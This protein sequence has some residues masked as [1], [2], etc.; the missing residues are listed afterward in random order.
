[1]CMVILATGPLAACNPGQRAQQAVNE[2]KSGDAAACVSER[3]IFQKAVEAYVLLN[4]DKPITEA[5]LV[6]AGIVHSESKLMD[7]MADGSVVPAP[8]SVCL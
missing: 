1:M 6:S 2:I 8:G 4:P 3:M 7:V 5:A